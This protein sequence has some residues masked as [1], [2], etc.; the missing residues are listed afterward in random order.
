[1]VTELVDDLVHL[2]SGEDG[3]DQHG[4]ADGATGHADVVLGK[5]EDIVPETSLEMRLHLGEVEVGAEAALDGLEGVVEEVQTK[6]EERTADGLTVDGDVLLL[7]VPATG[8]DNQGREGAVGAELVL[9]VAL[10]EVDLAA[11]SIVQVHLAV[12]HVVPGRGRGVLKVGH[13]GPDVGVEGVDDHLAVRG[14]GDLDA[15]VAETR[16]RGRTLPCGVLTDVLGLGE[17]VGENSL[18]QL[19][20]ANLAA[21]KELLARLVEGAVQKSDKGKS[22]GSQDLPLVILHLARDGHALEKRLDG[23]HCVICD[24]LF[25]SETQLSGRRRKKAG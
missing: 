25:I 10:L 21:L 9:L 1:M 23:S 14:A 6:V 5:V 18:V 13:V 24:Y 12:D 16:S 15:A 8:A 11:N 3:L 7:K 19:S 2:E 17:E 4:T 22:L 20:L